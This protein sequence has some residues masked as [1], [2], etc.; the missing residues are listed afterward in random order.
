MLGALQ[1]PDIKLLRMFHVVAQCGGF[2]AAQAQ[3]NLSQSAISTQMAQLETRLG[4][5][6]C[7]RGHGAFKL[8]SEGRA[9]I[10][11]SKKL[12]G[13]LQDFRTEIAESQGRLSG[14]LRLG[15]LDNCVTH[16]DPLIRD[17]IARFV[18]VAEE[19]H[20]TIYVGG[21]VELEQQVLDDRLQL[22][23]GV[24]HHE[25]EAIDYVPIMEEEHVLY[26]ASTHPFFKQADETLD[27]KML[28]SCRYASWGYGEGLPGWE[29]PVR[30]NEV[31][32]S[33]YIEGIA[34]LI[35]SGGY[36]G[37]LPTH[38]AETW[39]T[40]SLMRPILAEKTRRSTPISLIMRKCRR[41]S[42]LMQTFADGLNLDKPA[43][44]SAA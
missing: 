10:R 20:I 15:L 39:V 43:A 5:R 18:T 38:Y 29:P 23:I 25:V 41:V 2:S 26:C 6:L 14:E 12:F 42:R 32:S 34:Y 33:P 30:F 4:C 7:E 36:V 11:A 9:V 44:Q 21:A 13:A 28:R 27:E 35:L 19:A 22:A 37:Y 40:R 24:F 17:A 1:D 16:T 3:L 31:A 8:T